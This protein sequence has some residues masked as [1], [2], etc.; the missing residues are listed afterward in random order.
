MISPAGL[1]LYLKSKRTRSI[2]LVISLAGSA[3]SVVSLL[4]GNRDNLKTFFWVSVG[5]GLVG[6]GFTMAANNQRDQAVWTR[7]RDAMLFL[8]ANQ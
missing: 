5:T 3:G 8:E 2:G 1:G 4:T 6:S 7:N